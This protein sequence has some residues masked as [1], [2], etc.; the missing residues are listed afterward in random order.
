[1]AWKL[2][3]SE[4]CSVDTDGNELL[5]GELLGDTEAK[6]QRRHKPTKKPNK[7]QESPFSAKI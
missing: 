5:C 2:I 1:M 4:V 6:A 7:G 3:R